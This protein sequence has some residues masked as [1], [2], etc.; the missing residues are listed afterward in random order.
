[1][2]K[3]IKFRDRTLARETIHAIHDQDIEGYLESLGILKKLRRGRI[4]CKFCRDP[5]TLE[6]LHSL[7]PQSGDVKVV[8]EKP[9]CV[10]QLTDY[11]RSEAIDMRT[12]ECSNSLPCR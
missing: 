11:L 12:N 3:R 4:L 6:T 9:S 10:L 2:F 8:C 7:F 1:M 5:V